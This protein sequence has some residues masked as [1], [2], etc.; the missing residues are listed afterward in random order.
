MI[1]Y[2]DFYQRFRDVI[3]DA[4]TEE[5]VRLPGAQLA[6]AARAGIRKIQTLFPEARLDLRGTR[7][8]LASAEITETAAGQSTDGA[9]PAIPLPDEF[10]PMLEAYVLAW[11]FARD[12]QDVKDESL[13]RHWN[14]RFADLAGVPRL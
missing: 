5:S 11:Y 13:S 1:L 8:E 7:L 3:K 4:A 9:Y 14:N 10:E 2:K 12:S 6:L